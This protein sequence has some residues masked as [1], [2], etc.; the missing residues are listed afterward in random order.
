METIRIDCEPSIKSKILEFLSN[1]SSNDYKVLNEDAEFLNQK[2]KLEASLEKIKNG[3]AETC[4]LE[5]LD[6][7]LDKTISEYEN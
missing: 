2:E 1:F 6:A 3:T 5:E 4:S 7:F